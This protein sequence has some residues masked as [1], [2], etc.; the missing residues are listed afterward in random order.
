MARYPI[1][2]HHSAF[3]HHTA[4]YPSNSSGYATL[5]PVYPIF[6]PVPPPPPPQPISPPIRRTPTLHYLLSRFNRKAR[7]GIQWDM[8][9]HLLSPEAHPRSGPGI[10]VEDLKNPVSDSMMRK[11]KIVFGNSDWEVNIKYEGAKLETVLV[12]DVFEELFLFLQSPIPENYWKGISALKRARLHNNRCNRLAQGRPSL[13][14]IDTEI[15]FVDALEGTM[16]GGLT[17]MPGSTDWVVACIPK[18]V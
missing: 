11:M 6:V 18:K 13:R 8:R 1:N 9:Y 12:E 5:Y 2:Q 16:F 3:N 15:R 17:Q 4:L 14:D 10:R 7:R